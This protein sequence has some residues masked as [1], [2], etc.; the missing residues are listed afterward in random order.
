MTA[1]PRKRRSPGEGGCWPYQTSAGERFR[2]AGPVLMA[3]G[4]AK[5]A[6]KRGFM[7]KRDGQNWLADQ[8]SAGR[9]GEYVEPSR[10]RL[11][12][13]GAEV[14]NGM[15]IGP[16]TWRRTRRTGG[17]TSSPTRSHSCRWRSSAGSG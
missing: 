12:A 13:Y 15:R 11:G 16:Q 4:T 1:Q 3:D 10:Q 6:R 17:T 2:A 8:Q 9:K 5:M 7:T 14:I